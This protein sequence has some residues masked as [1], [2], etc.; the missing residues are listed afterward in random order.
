MYTAFPDYHSTIEDMVAEG[1][2]VAG[3][4]TWQGTHQ[5]EYFNTAPTGKKVTGTMYGIYR[6]EEGKRAEAW[7]LQDRLS[8]FQQ[9]GVTPPAG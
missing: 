9:L 3:R 4:F 2:K 8:I 1:D 7:I 6:F 5:R